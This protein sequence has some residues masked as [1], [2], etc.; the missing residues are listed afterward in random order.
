MLFN[1]IEYVIFLPLV[2]VLYY[3]I[4]SRWRWVLLL[5]A[6]Y[7]FYMCWKAEYLILII[8]STGIDYFA[9]LQMGKIKERKKRKKYLILSLISNLG[10]LFAFKYFN[11]F[12]DT[13]RT[14][15][16]Q[17]N[18]FYNIPEFNILL[19]VGIS[20]YTFQ[21][22]S[23]SIE[24]YWGKQKPEKHL[25]FFALYVSFFPQLVA[26][27]IERYDRLGPQ[28]QTNHKINYENIINGLN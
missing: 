28:L 22:L 6:S 13:V 17:F 27:P 25:G 9:G 23:Y 26:G 11:F 21:T 4:P 12:N 20:F 10:I 19:P 5:A 1:S 2:V 16:D 8:V 7:Y 14:V 3:L 24:V 15:F 18:L